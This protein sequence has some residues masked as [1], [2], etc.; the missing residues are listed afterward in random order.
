MKSFNRTAIVLG[1]PAGG[2]LADA[3]GFFPALVIGAAAMA[4]GGVALGFSGLRHAV[5]D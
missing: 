2:V 3:V 4:A 5:R 1:A